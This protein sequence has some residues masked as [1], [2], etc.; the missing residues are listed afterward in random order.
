MF[1][2]AFIKFRVS[3]KKKKNLFEFEINYFSL[4]FYRI[5]DRS[6]SSIIKLIKLN[7]LPWE[8]SDYD[9]SKFDMYH[10]SFSF[11]LFI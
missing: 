2:L 3:K 7:P 8:V 1:I 5:F 11:R 9:P 4:L 6:L 10:N